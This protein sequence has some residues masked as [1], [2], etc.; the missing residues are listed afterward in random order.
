MIDT[1]ASSSF[2]NPEFINLNDQIECKPVTISTVLSK[3]RLNKSTKLPTFHEFN[4]PGQLNFLLFKF[5]NYFDGL[6]GLDILSE[7]RAKI[8]L[9][10]KTLNTRN[11]T[12]PLLLKPNFNSGK[13]I[14][15]ANSKIIL[16]IP[17]DVR[18]GD[19]F[20]KNTIIKPNL[21]ISEGLYTVKDWFCPVEISNNS[22]NNQTLFMEQPL[23]VDPYS[24]SRFIEINNFNINYDKTPSESNITE[25]LR[26]SHLN[27]EE[28]K[29]LTKI[30]KE[31]ED[32]FFKEGQNLSFS[33][34]IKH[35]ILTTDNIPIYTKSY[36]YPYCHKEEIRQQINKMLEQGIIRQSY[37]PW[38]SPV[39][40]VPKKMDA[41]G[42][43]KWRLVIDYRK[44]NE[45]SISDRYP[46]PNITEILDKLGKCMYF[47][48]LD[49]ASGFHQIEMDPRD[50]PKTAFSVDG[51]HY[52]YLRMPFGLKNAPS[53]FQ[54]IMDN[55]LKDLIGTSCLVYLDDIIVYSTSL[56]E[57]LE[58][59]KKV[60]TKLR[61]SNLKVQLDKSDF[62][63]KEIAFL[64]HVVS[65]EGVK[66]N[67]DKIH[68]IKNFPLPK[69]QKEIRSFLG[70]LGYYRKFIKDFAKL[71]KPL[72][73]CL[74]KD[75]KINFTDQYIQ[76]F[77]TCKN[78]LTNEPILQYPDFSKP[79][80]LT[81]DASNFA[82]GAI[83][84][85]G[86]IGSDKPICFASRTL[87]TSEINYSTIEKE[88]L[89]I[90]WAAKYFRPYLFGHK[91]KIITD[92]KP[93]T[94]LMSLKEPNSKLIRWRLK[95]EE[96][97]YEIVYKKGKLNTNADA[98]SRIKL[99]DP[100]NN[101]YV[102]INTNDI[103][104]NHGT[105]GTTVHSAE[106]NL[107]DGI[108]ISEKPLNDFSLQI[109]LEKSNQ[110][111][112]VS[113]KTP[114]RNKQRRIIKKPEFTEEIMIDIFK[115]FTPPN[116]LSAI[117]T[118]NDTFRIVQSTYSKFFAHN[119]IFRLI[120]CTEILKDI[121]E[122]DE[123]DR[124]IKEYHEANNHR[125]INETLLHLKR[126]FYF[127]FMKNKITVTINRCEKCQLL[128]YDR[129]PPKLKY[130]KPESPLKPLDI[131]H[132]DIYSINNYQI[133]TIID[134]FS[135]FAAA[136]TL[137]TRN[138]LS[139]IKALRNFI[140][141]YGIPQK[142]VCDQGSEFTANIFKDFCDQYKINLHVTSF[143]QTSSNSTV[144]RLH[145]TLTEI[146]RIILSKRK[147]NRLTIDHD[148]IISETLITYNNAI[149]ST[150][151]YTPYE[152]LFGRTYKFDKDITFNNE[153]DYL[154]KLNEFQATLYPSIKE[155]VE[156]I[157]SSRIDKLNKTR[158]EP[159]SRDENETIF[160]RECKRNKLTPRFTKHKVKTN[161]KVTLVT[162]N[163]KK[164]HKSR[165]KK[166]PSRQHEHI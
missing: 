106:E 104:S 20:I 83:L 160:R 3:Y 76:T 14:I 4:E 88:L 159:T 90:V 165:I 93:L 124:I 114:F 10:N 131:I 25:L 79:F 44:L 105:S 91:F 47:S 120:R 61:E 164:V 5:H 117:F 98:L 72:T 157:T 95:L 96:F 115:K 156:K 53:T 133:L 29:G 99:N 34:Q 108:H 48:T 149:H 110:N 52:E 35:R 109:I 119:K 63:R 140:S 28:K 69:T 70:L 134:K 136:F 89:A 82:I 85:Q 147:E 146:Y 141:L 144:E 54:R 1:G 55:I 80:N 126:Q 41:S 17:V 19:V 32:I 77:E 113:V 97:D 15:P 111:P 67:P 26:I 37:S 118:D 127:P 158:E 23:K 100:K 161:N 153:H 112:S 36:R 2:I 66:P 30:C 86:P 125:G 154:Q 46:I 78:I 166:R 152:L 64:G 73:E 128:K 7:L 129:H 137:P 121:T 59:L 162:M 135:R 50:I 155:N 138:S 145:S 132:I 143:Q 71:V 33:N 12:L 43:K 81:T 9:E 87:T 123:Q 56:Q 6:L 74:K 57:H 42:K 92:H 101:N 8:D 60:F 68:A 40:I 150:T 24:S 107:D 22:P 116:K 18:N 62:L 122:N 38:S 21:K 31:F 13:H 163:N 148:D 142:I 102:D 139:V 94:W 65:T 130:E 39:W 51:G 58:N 84:S 16:K 11:S 27:P 75:R 45:K 103:V 49:L 151:K